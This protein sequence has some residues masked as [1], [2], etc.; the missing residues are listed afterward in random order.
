[1]QEPNSGE[2]SKLRI[3]VVEDDPLNQLLCQ[4]MVEA[5]G[6]QPRVVG[7][8]EGALQALEGGNIDLVLM[9]HHL[10]GIDG[11]TAIRRW[12]QQEKL[13]GLRPVPV[14][15]L[16]GN[17]TQL[18]LESALAA[19]L[20]DLLGKPFSMQDLRTAIDNWR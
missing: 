18:D 9:D 3:L 1:M 4:E 14:V 19:G 13:R 2:N 6:H 20:N 12:R 5:L 17:G 8:G 7:D 15:G 16:S 10:P 11:W